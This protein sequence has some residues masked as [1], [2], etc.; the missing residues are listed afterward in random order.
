MDNP[1]IGQ[2]EG[3]Q[4]A[5]DGKAA[6]IVGSGAPGAGLGN[7]GDLYIDDTNGQYY[8]KSGG[9]WTL[10]GPTVGS[11]DMLKATYDP[12]NKNGDAFDVDNHVDGTTNKVFTAAE[13]TNLGNQS[14]TN[15]G[16]EA[17]AS[18]TVEGIVERATDAEAAAGTDTT[19][20][21][22]PK[23]LKDNAGGVSGVPCCNFGA[24]SD[25]T[26]KFLVAN[27]CADKA[28]DTSK[29][30][31]R[32]TVPFAGTLT[33]LVYLT[34]EADTTT[35]MKI[36]VNGV[37]EATVLL[38]NVQAN[39]G[40]AETISVSVSDFDELEIEYD[41]GQKPAECTMYFIIEP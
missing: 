30:K 37:V 39:F 18:T 14:G 3:L 29:T 31:T 25:Q 7:D 5:L 23:Q 22:T 11:G 33:K 28:D 2:I 40:G 34:K 27:G 4:A 10:Q 20:Y 17:S 12:T 1:R 13:K 8:T 21:V 16:D 38:T 35:Q 32:C 24:K 26:G 41:A 36:H 6:V 19:R 15:T 9:T